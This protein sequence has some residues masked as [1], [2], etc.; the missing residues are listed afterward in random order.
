MFT[1][2]K[3]LF[4]DTGGGGSGGGMSAAQGAGVSGAFGMAG[5]IIGAVAQKKANEKIM[6][7]QDEWKYREREWALQ[8]WNMQNEYNLPINQK[9]RLIEA[10]LNPALLYGKGGD[11]GTATQVRAAQGQSANIKAPD[12]S[13]IAG[14]AQNSIMTYLAIK[15]QTAEIN[16]MEIQN[17]LLKQ[18]TE[19]QQLVN[20]LTVQKTNLTEAQVTTAQAWVDA[21]KQMNEAGV[22]MNYMGK[23]LGPLASKFVN[24]YSLTSVDIQ[25]KND[26]NARREL[27]TAANLTQIAERTALMLSQRAKTD[28]EKKLISERIELAKK[29]GILMQIDINGMKYLQGGS[30]AANVAINL[31]RLIFKGK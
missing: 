26:E 3:H 6:D 4:P 28:E 10:G 14:S 21:L 27:L 23:E 25:F 15:K 17:E 22:G 1:I 31:L 5:T 16:Q 7:Y 20:Q 9:K 12:F 18:K 2:R 13:G 11:A 30:T 29:S 24:D 19:G 8:D